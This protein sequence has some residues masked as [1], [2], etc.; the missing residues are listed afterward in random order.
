MIIPHF[1]ADPPTEPDPTP[2]PWQRHPLAPTRLSFTQA[3]QLADLAARKLGKPFHVVV[4]PD[5]AHFGD[6]EDM[7]TYWLDLPVLYS[8]RVGAVY[9][10]RSCGDPLPSDTPLCVACTEAGEVAL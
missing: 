3:R 8:T 1:T 2:P 5:G 6:A 4:G 10:C 7:L 9:A